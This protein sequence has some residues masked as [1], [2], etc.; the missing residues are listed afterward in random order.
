MTIMTMTKLTKL[1][2]R[3]GNFTFEDF[4]IMAE[5]NEETIKSFLSEAVATGK[6][7]ANSENSYKCIEFTTAIQIKEFKSDK[8]RA[9]FFSQEEINNLDIERNTLESFKKAPLSVQ[10]MINKYVDL[11]KEV[12]NAYGKSVEDYIVN[13]WNI[14]NPEQKTSKG[15]FEK[16]R[17]IL[18][19]NGIAGLI[20][21]ARK[22]ISVNDPIDEDVYNEL[23]DYFLQ[24]TDKSL[25]ENYIVFKSEYLK[26]NPDNE[27][28]EF[29][30]YS[31]VI[32]RIKKD[33]L[34]FNDFSLAKMFDEK[35]KVE[36]SQKKMGFRT[37]QPASED[38]LK[39]LFE[40]NEFETTTLDNYKTLINSHL[41]PFFKNIKLKNINAD[42]LKEYKLLLQEQ[43]YSSR[44][45]I[46]LLNLV[47]KI[48]R[49]Y[50][51]KSCPP[52]VTRK[53]NAKY[54][55]EINILEKKKII[56]LLKTCK[57]EFLDFYPLL[58]TAVNTGITRGEVLALTWDKFDK[59]NKR[60]LIN[61]SIYK[62]QILT[63]RTR[64]ASRYV[65][66]PDIL[67]EILSKLRKD[68]TSTYIF[69]NEHGRIQDPEIMVNTKFLPLVN[70]AGLENIRFIDLRDSYAAFLIEQ[71]IPLTYVKTQLGFTNLN[72]LVDRYKNNIP[73]KTKENFCLL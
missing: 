44:K 73:R 26:N 6:I 46:V 24:H 12:K 37:F 17:K 33:I 28:W 11:L 16:T 1:A 3:L 19:R 66:L 35:K 4:L 21:P 20:S 13:V 30:N 38:Y 65:D 39:D 42:K 32:A 27:K 56:R 67:I 68:S 47:K 71:N 8:I 59:E 64:E 36:I 48:L 18:K 52:S 23:K 57:K 61:K 22:Y 60:L 31:S 70:K 55:N 69:P 2:K 34:K 49:I 63:L 62:G 53:I 15:S 45:I 14:N 5:E 9:D 54:L 50:L 43:Q 51:D 58:V 72:V 41:I 29:P 25:R 7:I 40:K 10:K